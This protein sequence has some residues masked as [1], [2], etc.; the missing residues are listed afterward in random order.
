MKKTKRR[1]SHPA[2][3]VKTGSIEDFF[4]TVGSVM[5]AADKNMPIKIKPKTI[6]FEDPMD[7]LYFLSAGKLK[8]IN[9][10]RQKPDSVTNLAKAMHRK[11]SAVARDVNDL[12]KVGIVQIHS[13]INPGHGRRKIIELTA[14][15]LTLE[16]SI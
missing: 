2:I 4:A 13:E 11:V 6:I 14:K 10:I 1:N 7:M 8:L 3:K 9:E 16:A 15:K 5:Q 12:E